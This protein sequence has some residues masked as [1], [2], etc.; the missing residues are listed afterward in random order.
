[1]TAGECRSYL[2]HL[3]RFGIKL[4]LDNIRTLLG[5]FGDPHR[6]YPC[7]H[8]A[9]TNGKGS[10]CAM[11]AEALERNGLKVGLYT[12]PHLVR[13]EER[14]RIGRRL[15]PAADFRR[16]A[17]EVKD[18][19][20]K[21]IANAALEAPP[22]FFEV[23][24]AIAMLYFREKKIEIAVFEVGM[25]GRFDAT[26]VVT[27]IVAVITNIALDHQEYLGKTMGAIAFEKAGI[28][29]PGVPVVTG[30]EGGAALK[31]I[32]ARAKEAGAPLVKAF[33]A[34]ARIESRRGRNGYRF[35]YRISIPKNMS[36]EGSP[37]SEHREGGPPCGGTRAG[38]LVSGG[39]SKSS[40]FR[41]SPSLP[42]AHQGVNAAVA[43]ATLSVLSRIWCPLDKGKMVCGIE[44]ARWEGRLEL[45]GKRPQYYLDGAHNAAGAVVLRA[46]VRD[47]L[48]VKP[49]MV[50]A[51]M[52]DKAIG[53]AVRLLFPQAKKIIL[54]SIPYARAAKPEEIL[55]LAR[56]FERKIA[57]EP[58]LERALALARHLAGP[59]GIVLAAGSLYLVGAVK[60][61]LRR[62]L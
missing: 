30:V 60:K 14:I 21:L 54:T 57:I 37:I 17:G 52:K 40:V 28:I 13:V 45:V 49:V 62:S 23:L 16:L 20:E 42:G 39:R 48:K 25:G 5:A 38:S 46:F 44:N 24:T 36:A 47:E 1:M 56:P 6:A 33:G 27:P 35:N 7:V 58:S 31:V 10:V 59:R 19:S 9:G 32:R 26:N 18:R 34:G 53:R 3:E 51:M 41:F 61:I 4:G 29:K 50:F 2:K 43:L 22:T 55:A 12:S 15:I 11:I 8:V